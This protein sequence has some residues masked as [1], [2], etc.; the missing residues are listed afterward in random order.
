LYNKAQQQKGRTMQS[1]KL[2]DAT[3][4]RDGR[5][6]PCPVHHMQSTFHHFFIALKR[7]KPNSFFNLKKY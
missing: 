7:A 3:L 4:D 1:E 2:M 5:D 6:H